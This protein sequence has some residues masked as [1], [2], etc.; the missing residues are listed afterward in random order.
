VAWLGGPDRSDDN[1][2]GG[3]GSPGAT[4]SG[5]PSAGSTDP[6]DIID[7]D[8]IQES[9]L[10]DT[11]TPG[12]YRNGSET[13]R[14]CKWQTAEF[15]DPDTDLDGYYTLLYAPSRIEVI[16]KDRR[17]DSVDL[18]GIPDARAYSNAA[19]TGCEVSWP[20]SFGYAIVFGTE[21]DNMLGG[22]CFI[23]ARFARTVY[24]KVPK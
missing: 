18:A 15:G 2:A 12:G 7:H 24:P 21:G 14:S 19:E 4:R 23:V 5:G 8:I 20:T 17:P 22:D 11:G 6:C 9:V 1:A 3:H 16:S 13:I 10:V